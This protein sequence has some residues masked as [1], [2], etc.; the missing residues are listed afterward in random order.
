MLLAF[1]LTLVMAMPVF[2]NSGNINNGT[3]TIG[4]AVEGQDYSIY[5]IFDLDS[6]NKAEH[7]YLYR[8]NTGWNGFISQTDI[9]GTGGY[10]E[11]DRTTGLVTWSKKDT[12]G[13][14]IGVAEFAA[15]ALA[16]AKDPA[17]SID[18][19]KKASSNSGNA[20]GVTVAENT[21]QDKYTIKFS[22]LGL[23]YYLVDS[24]LGALCALN[25]TSPD[26]TMNDKNG[27]PTV[28]KK[29]KADGN[30]G[31]DISAQ[32]GDTVTFQ[33]TITAAAGAE[34]YVLHDKMTKGLAFKEIISVV[35][36]P[37]V[38]QT[39]LEN[40]DYTLTRTGLDDG[41]SFELKFSDS[42]CKNLTATDTIVVTY[43]ATLTKDAE[44]GGSNLN[45]NEAWLKYGDNPGTETTHVKTSVHTYQIQLVKTDEGKNNIYN[46]LTDAEFELYDSE[47]GTNA[48]KVVEETD[49]N[50]HIVDANDQTD[51]DSSTTVIKA[52]HPIIKG[53][54][55]KTY[56]LEETKA[57]DGFNKLTERVKIQVSGNNIIG[58]GKLITGTGPV[59]YKPDAANPGGIQIINHAGG[60]LPSTG[61]IGT[62]LFYILG[63][64]LVIGA[65]AMLI[66]RSRC[67]KE[68]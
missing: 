53:L 9:S 17:N 52:G 46:V 6:Y 16:Y 1:V 66:M 36:N 24:S 65:I 61:G 41:C 44:I 49:G 2:A 62:V 28:D 57:P 51:I 47:I 27:E 68:K 13:N 54:D 35:K 37:G 60:M 63:T 29:V 45:T 30:F 58:T 55:K 50:Y 8:V 10:V 59:Q 31:T 32:I 23:G 25:T 18:P 42:V 56:W 67:V 40:S 3:I 43:T 15:K 48:I 11:V 14:P 21:G 4:N 22:N 20:D 5:R 26:A 19:V 33:A 34:N 64:A 12:F 38:S 39:K 7:A